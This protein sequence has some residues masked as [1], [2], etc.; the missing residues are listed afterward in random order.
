M[1]SEQQAEPITVLYLTGCSK[2]PSLCHPESFACH[3]EGAVA[4]EESYSG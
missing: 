1:I 3:S 4:T 2:N